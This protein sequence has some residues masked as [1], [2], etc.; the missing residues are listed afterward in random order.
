MFGY[1]LFD[2]LII[3]FIFV[4]DYNRFCKLR[5]SKMAYNEDMSNRPYH[6]HV[7]ACYVETMPGFCQV[8]DLMKKY[9]L[10]AVDIGSYALYVTEK[11]GPKPVR[12]FFPPSPFD[13]HVN[14][15]QWK[16][17]I[18]QDSDGDDDLVVTGYVVGNK[19]GVVCKSGGAE[20]VVTGHVAGNKDG[21]VFKSGEEQKE[22]EVVV[23]GTKDGVVGKS[24][25]A[26]VVVT[27]YVVG[28]KDGVVFKSG[29]EQKEAEVVVVDNKDGVVCKSGEKQK[30]AEAEGSGVTKPIWK[31]SG[32]LGPGLWRL[33][34]GGWEPS[35]ISMKKAQPGPAMP[36][37]PRPDT[38]VPPGWSQRMMVEPKEE[39][40]KMELSDAE[41]MKMELSDAEDEENKLMKIVLKM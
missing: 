33:R 28:N 10:D 40:M 29:E 9:G 20:V 35:R 41:P 38:P 31:K 39:P 32:D 2:I 8:F 34:D 24:G 21:V 12:R 27:G 16:K 23:V 13:R 26:E 25:G 17:L 15:G 18:A 11:C 30:E 3:F 19:D 6:E 37:P 22:A 1:L 7:D 14:G 5:K 36:G 4:I